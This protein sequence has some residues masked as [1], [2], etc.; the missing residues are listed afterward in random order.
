MVLWSI[1]KEE[2]VIYFMVGFVKRFVLLLEKCRVPYSN[3]NS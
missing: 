3:F 2:L 1:K